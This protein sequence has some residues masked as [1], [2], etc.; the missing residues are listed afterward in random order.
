[1]H[2]VRSDRLVGDRTAPGLPQ[3]S[4]KSCCRQ[5]ACSAAKSAMQ[6]CVRERV[7]YSNTHPQP[8]TP[9]HPHSNVPKS[10]ASKHCV[11]RWNNRKKDY[12]NQSR[13]ANTA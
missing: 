5:N 13:Q 11:P 9:Q 12:E 4:K 1:M 10:C 8:Y 2:V 6:H 3:S 7:H